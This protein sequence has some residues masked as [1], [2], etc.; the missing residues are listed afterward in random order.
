VLSGTAD[1]QIWQFNGSTWT[2]LTAG[3]QPRYPG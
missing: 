2:P 1:G 3:R